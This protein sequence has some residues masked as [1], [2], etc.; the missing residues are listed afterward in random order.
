EPMMLIVNYTPTYGSHITSSELCG[1]CHTVIIPTPSGE[2]VEQATFLEWRSSSY[3]PDR[4]CQSCHVPP[5]DNQGMPIS[6][7]V[8]SCPEDLAPRRP[9]GRHEHVG[10]NA[11]MLRLIADAIEWPDAGIHATELMASAAPSEAHLRT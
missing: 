10:G 4:T 1:T 7:P 3:A 6:T 5:I 9:A 11:Y 2:V 8:A